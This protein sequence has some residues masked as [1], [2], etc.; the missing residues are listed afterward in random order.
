[1]RIAVS[2]SHSLGKST[3]VN[4]WVASRNDYIREE[5]PYRVLGLQ[6][7]YEIFFRE[8]S[9]RLQNGIQ[10]YYSISRVHRYATSDQRVIFDR[11]P[12]D[13]LAYS[14][15]TANQGLT[16]IDD[17]FVR[18]ML[19]AVREALDHLD[20]LAFVPQSE[21]WPVAMENDGIRPVDQSYRSEV[22]TL[23]KQIYR[24]GCFEIFPLKNGPLLIE[25]VGPPEQRLLQLSE[26]VAH[27]EARSR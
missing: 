9:T 19:P 4:D 11:A 8:A 24:E 22:D 15:Y 10:L 18:S 17:A 16:D 1:M 2:G 6:G 5:E 20:I 7:P 14:Q 23:F 13:Y 27:L 12:V 26:A 25:L 21:V 3:V